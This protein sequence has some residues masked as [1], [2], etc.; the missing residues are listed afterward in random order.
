MDSR[1]TIYQTGLTQVAVV[2]QNTAGN[3]SRIKQSGSTNTAKVYQVVQAGNLSV[4][5]QRGSNNT[6]TVNQ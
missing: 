6:A 5:R 2:E 1:S 3:V 4:I